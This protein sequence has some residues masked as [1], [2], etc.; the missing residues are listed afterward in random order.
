MA[1]AFETTSSGEANLA[2]MKTFASKLVDHFK[3]SESASHISLSTFSETP[4]YISRFGRS[5][6]P[7]TVK[8]QIANLKSDG[9]TNSN[10]GNFL[11]YAA[12]NLFSVDYGVRQGQ[13]RVLVIFTN[14]VYPKDQEAKAQQAAQ[15][16]KEQ[17]KDVSI[18]V[19]NV[20][21]TPQIGVIENIASEPAAAKVISV[22]NSKDLLTQEVKER[23]AV[24]ICA[25]M[26]FIVTL[27][28]HFF[29]ILIIT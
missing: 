18:V 10:I 20:G 9:G 22:P 6:E 7:S 26:L 25:G 5:H 12:N 11:E 27:L 13:P 15:K 23:V 17:G 4:G 14:G 2:D 21:A 8:T 24:E 3:V 28:C 19:V 29:I 16:L 1:F